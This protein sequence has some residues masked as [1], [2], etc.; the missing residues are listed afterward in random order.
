MST[1]ETAS[2]KSAIK[3]AFMQVAIRGRIEARRRHD[4]SFYSR[5][6]CPAPDP[7][8][9]P[10]VVEVRSKQ[11]FGEVGEEI[12]VQAMLGGYAGK[13]FKVTD[14]TTGEI[15]TGQSY[16]HTLDAIE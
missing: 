15:R 10:Q 16:I 13:P 8:S 5:V 7:Y 11:Y 3:P 14:Q 12:T 1:P 4:K 9:R 2:Q 6:V